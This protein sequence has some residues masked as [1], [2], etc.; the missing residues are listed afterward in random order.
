MVI[1]HHLNN[2][3][4]QT[5]GVDNCIKRRPPTYSGGLKQGVFFAKSRIS[6]AKGFQRVHI[7]KIYFWDMTLE[8]ISKIGSWSKVKADLS[9]NPQAY[10]SMSRT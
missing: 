7:F 1:I 5:D 10:S 4:K 6:L 9:F 3:L 8:A 2:I